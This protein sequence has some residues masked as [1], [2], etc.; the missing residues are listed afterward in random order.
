MI[1][2]YLKYIAESIANP[3]ELVIPK[4]EATNGQIEVLLV[5]LML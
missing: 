1:D 5:K 2:M 4:S 3:N